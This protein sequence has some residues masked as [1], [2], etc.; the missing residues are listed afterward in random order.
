MKIAKNKELTIL[1]NIQTPIIYFLLDNDEVV[2]V[3]QSKA[4]LSRPYSHKDKVFTNVAVIYCEESELDRKE[5]DYIRK[6][7]PKYNMSI[8]YCDFSFGKARDFI[9]ENTQIKDFTIYDLR[10]LIKKLNIETYE[11]RDLFY[12][13]DKDFEKIIDY[14]KNTTKDK[15]NV[16]N[17]K[18]KNLC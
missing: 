11:F 13:N 4:G 5:T 8:G 16:S 15:N 6:Y 9:R 3:G 18:Y 7:N 12:I 1:P 2:Y 14:I 17:W 10:K